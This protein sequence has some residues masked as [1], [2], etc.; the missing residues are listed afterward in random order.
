MLIDRAGR[1]YSLSDTRWRGDDGSPLAVS[2][3]PGVTRETVD[4]GER[5]LWRYA[6]A[7]PV[8]RSER[9]SLEEGWTPLVEVAWGADS[10]VLFKL[11]WFNPTSS[12]K[13]RGVSVM[14]SH[15]QAQGV[16]RVLEDSSGNGGSAVAAY[17]AAAGIRERRSSCR[18]RLGG[19]DPAD[20]GVRGGDRAGRRDAGPGVGRGDSAVCVDSVRQPQLAPV[21]HPGH[22]DDRLRDVGAAGVQRSGQ[23]GVGRRSGQQHPRL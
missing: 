19:E 2:A 16:T 17:A 5:S 13:D 8:E 10:P 1:R 18:R 14:V 11:E 9:V 6:A 22:E 7:L 4:G 21:L 15:L 3:L 12:F 20:P 23:R